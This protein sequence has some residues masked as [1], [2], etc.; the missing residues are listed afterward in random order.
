MTARLRLGQRLRARLAGEVR[1]Y[2]LRAPARARWDEG[3]WVIETEEPGDVALVD[4][5]VAAAHALLPLDMARR[6][7]SG[8]LSEVL[9]RRR[10]VEDVDSLDLDLFVRLLGF[11]G[12]AERAFRASSPEARA[13]AEQVAGGINAWID[14]GPW[15]VDRGWAALGT[16]P[17]LFGPADVLL[18]AV[19]PM[20]ADRAA[21]TVGTEHP[22]AAPVTARL[23]LLGHPI[24]RGPR[25][26]AA[27]LP[28]GLGLR[29][30]CLL[31]A[32]FPTES[33]ATLTAEEVLPGG[34]DHRIVTSRGWARLSVARPDVAVRGARTARPWL[35]T[36]PRGPLVSD[37]LGA[38]GDPP[39]GPATSLAWE[40]P[41][42][43]PASTEC[44]LPPSVPSIRLVPLDEGA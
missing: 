39:T 24:L 17:R 31:P 42:P 36:G 29:S 9:G 15:A 35:R 10:L 41:Q 40:G 16:R 38:K 26:F 19:G 44:Q 32:R 28:A 11:R 33:Q 5:V 7:W 43:A 27:P 20:L 21:A 14:D 25:G 30:P 34:D 18:L 4:G 2:G 13:R 22:L 3:R 37:L 8:R 23:A 1:V 6:T 12:R